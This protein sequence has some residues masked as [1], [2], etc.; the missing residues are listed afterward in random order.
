MK[1]DRLLVAIPMK[2]PGAAKTRLSPVLAPDQRA[3]L[4]LFLFNQTVQRLRDVSAAAGP[5]DIA[6]VTSGRWIADW[7]ARAQLPVIADPDSGS[8][9]GPDSG[10]DSGPHSGLSAAA[11]AAKLWATQQGYD[12]LC[13]L[14][15]DLADPRPRDLTALLTQALDPGRIL[16][17]PA[18]DFGTNALVMPLPSGMRFAY[19]PHSFYRHCRRARD[20]GLSPTVLP[21]DSLRRD[22]D[23]AADLVHLS[24][25][26]PIIDRN[27]VTDRRGTACQSGRARDAD[28][29]ADGHP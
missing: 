3:Q 26:A 29:H 5:I 14:P 11:A 18:L 8:D 22:V 16:L 17:C 4:A 6:V 7:A 23:R 9:S 2:S 10:L 24:A 20:A 25:E 21:F 28:R 12:A 15:G 13:L 1:R 19:G 27:G